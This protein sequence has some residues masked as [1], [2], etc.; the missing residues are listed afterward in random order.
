MINLC[1][2]Q[3]YVC[4]KLYFIEINEFILHYFLW[5]FVDKL[6]KIESRVKNATP[7]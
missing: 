4:P 5:K 3:I 2:R 7:I 6:A 1:P